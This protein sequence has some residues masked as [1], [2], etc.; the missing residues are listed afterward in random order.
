MNRPRCGLCRSDMEFVRHLV[1][2]WSHFIC[3]GCNQQWSVRA[4]FRVKPKAAQP[5]LEVA[6]LGGAS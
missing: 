4:G 1:G 5:V 3:P 6:Q 2:V